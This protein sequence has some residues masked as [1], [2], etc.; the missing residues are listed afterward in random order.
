MFFKKNFASRFS[1]SRSEQ[2]GMLLFLILIVG[3]LY[4][5]YQYPWE[6][7]AHPIDIS[8]EELI[9]E[10][11]RIDS[12]REEALKQKTPRLYPFNPNF[13]TDYKAYVIGLST[14]EFDRL[15]AFREKGQWIN[16]KA[17]F[18]RVTHVSKEW[19][20]SIA[21]YFKFPAWVTNSKSFRS[22]KQY[23]VKKSAAEK[24]DLNSASAENLKEVYGVGPVL[25]ERIVAFRER[26]GGF[27]D[28]KQLYGVYGL[29][30][31]TILKIL[32][33]FTLKSPKP[34]AQM[35]INTA[36][37]SDLATLPGISFQLGKDIWE[38]VRLREGISTLGELENLEGLSA[39]QFK[40]IELYLF[41]E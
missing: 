37:A 27:A 26:I 3:L 5:K 25:S 35:N 1:F 20:D 29:R 14:E 33:D 36:T 21:P 41:A 11:K 23:S 30:E 16:S 12:L 8:S 40:L 4:V 38:F 24:V 28:E 19:M 17:D 22:K 32:D 13:I 9:A 18:Q 6:N 2:G 34:L 39:Q 15:Q 10:Q 31:E 7:H